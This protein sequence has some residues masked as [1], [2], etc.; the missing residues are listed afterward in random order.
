MLHRLLMLATRGCRDEYFQLLMWYWVS[1]FVLSYILSQ[2]TVESRGGVKLEVI[3]NSSEKRSTFQWRFDWFERAKNLRKIRFVWFNSNYRVESNF[4]KMDL[5]DSIIYNWIIRKV[6]KY[7]KNSIKINSKLN[8]I[9][10]KTLWQ[11]RKLKFHHNETLLIIL[12]ILL[13]LDCL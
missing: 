11:R 7:S 2:I 6:K 10:E 1:P 5:F 13:H 9:T 3:R 12:F 8:L 4:Q